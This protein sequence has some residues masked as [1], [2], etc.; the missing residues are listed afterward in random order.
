M[1][2]IDKNLNWNTVLK[3][4]INFITKNCKNELTKLAKKKILFTGGGGFLGY[5]FTHT[6]FRWNNLKENRNKKIDYTFIDLYPVKALDW[7]KCI[8]K[9][10]KITFIKK[11]I[12]DISDK[13]LDKF[14][15]IIHGASF[16]SPTFYRKRPIDTMKAN[17]GGLWK[18]LNYFEK[19]GEKKNKKKTLFF[20]SSSEVYGNPD[21]KNIPTKE[22]YFGNVS[23]FGP[24]AC[25]DESKRF[26]ETLILNYSAT[27]KFR[28]IIV[29]P[30]NNYGPGMS[31]TDKRVI[32]DI[33]N[34]IVKNQ[35]IQIFSNGNPTRT[36]CY[37]SDAVSGYIK[38]LVN[39]VTENAYNIGANKPEISIFN[40][41]KIVLKISKE[42]INYKKKIVFKKNKEKK[43]L[44]DNPQR[45]MPNVEKAKKHLKYKSKIS[46]EKGIK[47][48]LIYFFEKLQ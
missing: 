15:I 25:Y 32:P 4:D 22:S 37:I 19:S 1:I 44:T 9:K 20:F 14:D 30:F 18:I 48:S 12:N 35:N 8:G 28:S 6:I 46:L 29:R 23:F 27:Y 24:R 26:G 39:G 21:K 42:L 17:I 33:F 36:F 10:N 41:S 11:N 5:Y 45:R 31:L 43:Y 2:N 38:A 40:L 47:H 7:R 34:N 13:F 16:A 3:E